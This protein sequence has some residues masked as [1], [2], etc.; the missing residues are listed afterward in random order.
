MGRVIL[1]RNVEPKMYGGGETY[2][3]MLAQEF[4]R[5]KW[6]PI[7]VTSC[8]KLL[9]EAKKMGTMAVKAPFYRRQ[10]YSGLRNL[11]F[12]I[13]V[14]KQKRLQNWYKKLFREYQPEVINVQSR[15]DW[16]A[17]TKAAKKMRIRV[18]WTDHMDFRSWVLKNI[19]IWYKNW[20]GKWILK[21]AEDVDKIIMISDFERKWFEKNVMPKKFDNIVTIKNGVRDEYT[22]YRNIKVGEKSFCYVGRVVDY[23]GIAELLKAFLLVRKEIPEAKLNIYGEGDLEKYKKMAGDGVTFCGYTNNP[24][25]VIAENEIFVLPSYKEGLS[26]SL[27]DAAMMGKKIIASNVDG[28]PEVVVNE[29]T[30]LLIPVR[31]VSELAKAMEWMLNNPKKAGALAHGARKIFEEDF[32]FDKIFVEKMLPLYNIGKEKK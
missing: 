16:I 3:L 13:Y 29:K 22:K 32:N 11:L 9:S 8:E 31:N 14:V 30:G 2:Q 12:P 27:L 4:L 25:G 7:I 26:L 17:A 20:I 28:N 5:K 24:L 23:K 10:N 1:I 18:F 15:D 19:N 21:C 6:E